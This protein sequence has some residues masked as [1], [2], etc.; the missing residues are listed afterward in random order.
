M[1]LLREIW[2]MVRALV[3]RVLGAPDLADVHSEARGIE[4]RA[5]DRQKYLKKLARQPFEKAES[6]LKV[7]GVGPRVPA[8]GYMSSSY[9]R[10]VDN[11]DDAAVQQAE[12][13]LSHKP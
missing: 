2:L 6:E 8:R 11:V 12:K 9:Y 4:Q 13:A 10:R 1:R 7:R 5:V 3:R